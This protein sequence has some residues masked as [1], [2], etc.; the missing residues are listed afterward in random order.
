V[1]IVVGIL[2]A[3]LISKA[4]ATLKKASLTPNKTIGTLKEDKQWVQS[5]IS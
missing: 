4:L 5:K 1:A 2:A 3:I